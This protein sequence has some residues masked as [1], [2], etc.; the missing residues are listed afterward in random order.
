MIAFRMKVLVLTIV[1]LAQT[2]CFRSR[3]C[4]R[5]PDTSASPACCG[6]SPLITA[7]APVVPT[8]PPVPPPAQSFSIAP[9]C[10]VSAR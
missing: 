1:V 7:P 6:D 2:G 5:R 8:A 10:A 9:S 3:D 4:C